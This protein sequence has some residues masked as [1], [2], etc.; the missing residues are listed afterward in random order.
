MGEPTSQ[1]PAPT[2]FSLGQTHMSRY[3]TRD[4]LAELIGCLPTS[5]AC[6][7]R[8]LTKN[9]WP[10]AVNIAG[11]PLVSREYHYARMCGTGAFAATSTEEEPDFSAFQ[12]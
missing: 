8:L 12:L 1:R 4:E 3:L 7:K 11:V 6:M 5:S 2:G 9:R 10:F